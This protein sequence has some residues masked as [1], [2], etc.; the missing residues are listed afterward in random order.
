MTGVN[1]PRGI[2]AA[3]ATALAAQGARVLL[4]YLRQ[5]VEEYGLS[6]E[7][8]ASASEPGEALYRSWNA[9]PVDEVLRAI[10]DS[11]GEAAELEADLADVTS[12]P[13]LFDRAEESL[14]PIEILVNNAAYCVADTFLPPS[15][16]TPE[17][18]VAGGAISAQSFDRHFAV[19]GRAPAL[20]IAEFARRHAGRGASWGRIVNV[21]TD[22]ARTFP[23]QVS[24]GASKYALESYS[25]SAA[26]ELGP[27]G[28]TVNTVSLGAVQTGWIDPELQERIER[29]YPLGR[30]GQPEDVADV[31]VF[32][33]GE[34]ARWVT[35][36]TLFVGGGHRM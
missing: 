30:M 28:V 33:A 25:R 6:R 13:R 27:Y 21:S 10:R 16:P 17:A 24:Y 32:F 11:G 3:T 14:G 1:N 26:V 36:Q 29:D 18:L 23:G 5:P 9:L 15:A 34:R 20:L 12:I 22:G 35:G 19:N 7:D 8:V 2:G 31:V 4:T